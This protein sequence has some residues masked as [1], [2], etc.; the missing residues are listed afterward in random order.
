[1]VARC[2]LGEWQHIDEEVGA[3]E[4]LDSSV[5]LDGGRQSQA[6]VKAAMAYA[7]NANQM[8]GQWL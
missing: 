4:P 2:A 8:G 3:Y 7:S 5:E 1:M 6:A